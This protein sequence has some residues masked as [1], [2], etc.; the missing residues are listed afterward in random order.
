M[1]SLFTCTVVMIPLEEAERWAE[2]QTLPLRSVILFWGGEWAIRYWNG[3][4]STA[5]PPAQ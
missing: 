1:E 4:N 5:G 3:A 2:M